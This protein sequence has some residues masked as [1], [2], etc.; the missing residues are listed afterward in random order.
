MRKHSLIILLILSLACLQ[1]GFGQSKKDYPKGYFQW[2]IGAEPAIVANFGELR[3]NHFHMGLDGRTGG[4]ENYPIYAAAEGY[5]AKIKI[6][7]FGFGRCIY[8]N[9]PNGYTTVYAHLNDF[10]P[11]LEKY[12]RER[13]YSL[14]QWKV[15]LEDIP[16]QLFKVKKG[17][18]IAK[19]G[20]TGGSQGPHLHFEI[21]ETKT[22]KV[23]NPMLFGMPITDKIPPSILKLALYDREKSTYEQTPKLIQIRKQEGIYQTI[24]D[25]L[26]VTTNKISFGITS[27]DKYTGSTNQN[28]IF[29][30]TIYDQNRKICLFE[31]DGISYDHTRG[32]N[33]HIDHKTKFMGGSYIQH[34]SR[35]PGYSNHVYEEWGGDGV[36]DLSDGQTHDIR[37]E[38]EDANLNKSVIR[39]KAKSEKTE[40]KSKTEEGLLFKPEEMNVYDDD[41]LRFY[42]PEHYIYDHFHFNHR[43]NI[44]AGRIIHQVHHPMV[45][46][47]GYIN[48]HINPEI[49]FS[50]TSKVIMKRSYADKDDFKK[51][52]FENGYYRASF[53]E[54]G[55]YE[56]F[57]DREPPKIIPY[58]FR[59]GMNTAGMRKISF[60]ATD[61][62]ESVNFTGLLDGKW[63]L[64]SN[65]KGKIFTYEF[66]EH[67]PE[68]KHQ[69]MIIA[70]DM[71]GNKTTQNYSFTR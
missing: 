47:H 22:D 68:G 9:H 59:N 19:S 53:R 41:G 20:N 31:L 65:D 27:F 18:L 15:F 25:L 16:P 17:D 46:L 54:F 3:K 63:I 21:R 6:E 26:K 37:I 51:A 62:T 45:P 57:E 69:L 40:N 11:A 34:L 67:C 70:E 42:I 55:N 44:A 56:L 8:I 24:P 4:K 52:V 29:R 33:A 71:A 39:L 23:L 38:V 2:P 36:I 12:V 30:A 48:V 14:K 13:Q 5:V 10:Y 66:D 58:G 28:G 50:D 49:D 64:F 7:P 60:S 35:L 43:K 1:D 61:N 32:M